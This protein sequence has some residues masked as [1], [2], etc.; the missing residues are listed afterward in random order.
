[1]QSTDEC[2]PGEAPTGVQLNPNHSH[3]LLVDDGTA[4]EFGREV[5]FRCDLLDF[6]S[7]RRDNHIGGLGS[8]TEAIRGQVLARARSHWCFAR[9]RIHFIPDSLRD[10]VPLFLRRQCDRTLPGPRQRAHG[11]GDR[12]GLRGRAEHHPDHRR[13]AGDDVIIPSP[14]PMI[15]MTSSSPRL[16]S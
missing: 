12:A 15:V 5:G 4:G 11:A 9:P 3:Y 16:A 8:L 10:S 13:R 1:M 14:R 7:F 6:I 2:G